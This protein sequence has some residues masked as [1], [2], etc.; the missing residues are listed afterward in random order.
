MIKNY[1]AFF[2]FS[3]ALT[4]LCFFL[5]NIQNNSFLEFAKGFSTSLLIVSAIFKIKNDRS[6]ETN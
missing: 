2:K 6:P 1:H 4:V 5:G 3:I